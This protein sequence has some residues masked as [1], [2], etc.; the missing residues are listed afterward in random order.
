MKR[1]MTTEVSSCQKKTRR[2]AGFLLPQRTQQAKKT[3]SGLAALE[4]HAN[5]SAFRMASTLA[6]ASPNSICVFSL[7]NSGFCTPA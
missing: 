2:P 3:A 4:I 7:K 6:L 5:Y 1:T